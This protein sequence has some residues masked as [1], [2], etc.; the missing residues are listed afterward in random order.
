MSSDKFNPLHI[1]FSAFTISS[2]AGLAALLRSQNQLSMRAICSAILY[3][4]MTGLIVALTLYNYFG[5]EYIFLL[6]G[7]SGLAG[8]G[9]ATVI[10]FIVQ[11]IKT[12]KLLSVVRFITGGKLNISISAGGS[13]D[14][15]D[16]DEE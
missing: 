6:L 9:G 8:I 11:L 5:A 14:G 1:F 15:D 16:S 13:D 3:S 7:V 2:L 4:G 10:D 12:G